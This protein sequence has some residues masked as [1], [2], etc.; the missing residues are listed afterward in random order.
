MLS[1]PSRVVHLKRSGQPRNSKMS[2]S[3]FLVVDMLSIDVT[4]YVLWHLCLAGN[5]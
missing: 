3:P 2:I 5:W 4:C 1:I